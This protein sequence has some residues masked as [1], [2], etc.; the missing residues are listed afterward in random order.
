[1][2]H[3][4]TVNRGLHDTCRHR[5]TTIFTSIVYLFFLWIA[6]FLDFRMYLKVYGYL[7]FFL[8][9]ERRKMEKRLTEKFLL[10]TSLKRILEDPSSH[11]RDPR[12]STRRRR[13]HNSSDDGD[14]KGSSNTATKTPLPIPP[15]RKT[16]NRRLCVRR[17]EG[18]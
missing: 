6:V 10:I 5:K 14:G 7:F 9:N 15:P 1:M 18:R 17:D 12:R 2:F 13:D 3:S 11:K 16:F 4:W 8:L